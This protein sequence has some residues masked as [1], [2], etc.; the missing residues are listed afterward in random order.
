MEQELKTI[1]DGMKS[2]LEQKM[3]GLDAQIEAKATQLLKDAEAKMKEANDAEIKTIKD[4][5]DS[6]LNT[7]VAEM[8]A[9]QTN[10][11]VKTFSGV[12]AKT[13]EEKHNDIKN[14]TKGRSVSFEMKDLTINTNNSITGGLANEA[15][16]AVIRQG[17]GVILPTP[18]VNFA[19]LVATVTGSEDTIRIWRET[20]E[21]NAFARQTDKTASKAEQDLST[22]PVVFTASYLA[23]LYR[24]HKSMMRNLP[25][26]QNRLP[27]MLRRNYFK[28]E[29]NSF[30]TGLYTAATAYAGSALGIDAL[31]EA[32]GQLE[33]SDFAPN[34]VVINPADWA[35]L[36]ITKDDENGYTLPSTVAF[37]NGQLT[38]NGVPVFKATF[39][40]PNEFIVGDWSQAYKYV[41]DGLKVEFFEQDVDNVEKNAIT[42]RVEESNV[43]VIEQ[44]LAFIKGTL[45]SSPS[46]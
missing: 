27:Q 18:L 39:V 15:G 26:M 30:Y 42:V 43:L 19:Q 28:A 24:Y 44:P 1:L 45:F 31:V 8:K 46:V 23:G 2:N 17:D 11:E 21:T 34:G 14:V 22:P 40:A 33:G 41:T 20:A 16:G 37:V 35:Q 29:N 6:R 13:I 10:Q 38:V 9:K 3:S 4:D 5:F 7:I 25:W 36:S 12:F 32:I